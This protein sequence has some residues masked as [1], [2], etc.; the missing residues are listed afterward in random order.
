[1]KGRGG[2]IQSGDVRRQYAINCFNTEVRTAD[3]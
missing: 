2:E 3:R 1:M